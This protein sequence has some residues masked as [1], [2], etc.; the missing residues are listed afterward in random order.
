MSVCSCR[1]CVKQVVQHCCHLERIIVGHY[2]QSRP[3]CAEASR[4]CNT[5]FTWSVSSSLFLTMR[6]HLERYQQKEEANGL[7]A[8]WDWKAPV[9]YAPN[10]EKALVD[11]WG[12][13]CEP[14]AKK[15]HCCDNT[16]TSRPGWSVVDVRHGPH[17][18]EITMNG[19]RE[20]WVHSLFV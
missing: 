15:K 20:P 1:A 9:V 16:Y 2:V 14:P 6:Y 19:D 10:S 8:R 18:G 3:W 7:G 4:L 5:A 13:G 17:W 12:P 11:G